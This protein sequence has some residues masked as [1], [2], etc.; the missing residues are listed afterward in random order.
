MLLLLRYQQT[1]FVTQTNVHDTEMGN[2]QSG[3]VGELSHDWP[4]SVISDS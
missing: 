3:T 1:G 4:I 2:D